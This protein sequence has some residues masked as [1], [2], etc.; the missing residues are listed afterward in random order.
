MRVRHPI[1]LAAALLLGACGGGHL[2]R[3]EVAVTLPHPATLPPLPATSPRNA[4]YSID[5][6]L[7][8][9]R[10]AI[11]GREV[12]TWRNTSDRALSEFP[13][14]LYWNAFRNNRSTSAKGDGARSAPDE[15]KEGQ[16]PW[17]F[18]Q[19][20]A[21]RLLEGDA[22]LL[23]SLRYIQPDDGNPDDRTVAQ[24]TTPRPV[25]PGETVRFAI[26][27]TA[28]VPYGNTERSGWVHDYYFVAQWFPKIGVFWKGAWNAHQFHPNSEF[29][30]DYGVYDVRLTLPA[31][32]VVG[33]TGRV[34]ESRREGDQQVL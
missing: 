6:T 1:L 34:T 28:R 10:H 12:L 17:G 20:K 15:A 19:V 18:V 7:D 4:S 9:D 14:H 30:A 32:F 27:W 8:P 21:V 2:D 33:A 29:F 22:D 11:T 25:A 23:P 3:R 31:R 13:F 24:F 16:E 5:A 26:D